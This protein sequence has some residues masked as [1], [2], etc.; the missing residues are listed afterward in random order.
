MILANERFV[1]RMQVDLMEE[2]I[3]NVVHKDAPVGEALPNHFDHRKS[4]VDGKKRKVQS[5]PKKVVPKV[6]KAQRI[7]SFFTKKTK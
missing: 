7:S 1:R 4:N 3:K 2:P 5:N 6:A